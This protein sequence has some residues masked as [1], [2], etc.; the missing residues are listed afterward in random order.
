[1]TQTHA[2]VTPTKYHTSIHFQEADMQICIVT[3][4]VN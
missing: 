1:M 4:I 3:K 2:D